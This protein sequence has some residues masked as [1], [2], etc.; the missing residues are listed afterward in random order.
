MNKVIIY[1]NKLGFIPKNLREVIRFAEE[2]KRF[3]IAEVGLNAHL[4]DVQVGDNIITGKGGNLYVLKTFDKSV[5]E[6]TGADREYVDNLARNY[7]L[8]K[9]NITSVAH[10][11]K[12]STWCKEMRPLLG[13]AHDENTN[14]SNKSQMKN[15]FKN[16]GERLKAQFY[17]EKAEGVR[18]AM[19]GNICVETP[20]GYVAIDNNYRLISYPC[21]A[22][23]DLPAYTIAKPFDQIK[24]GDVILRAKSYAKVRS[25][26]DG[27]ISVVGYSGNGSNVYPIKD[28]LL[29]QATVRV[30]VSFT[31]TVDGQINPMMLF[32]LSDDKKGSSMLPLL[33]LSQNGG[34]IAQNPMMLALLA[35]DGDFDLK[36]IMMYS[37]L[38]GQNPFTNL[39]APAAPA[40]PAEIKEVEVENE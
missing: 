12:F 2:N 31:G 14:K 35:G 19:D 13:D 10:R 20:E 22:V 28:F 37:M 4:Q 8:Q 3:R 16:L 17:P 30:V 21:E 7:D 36:D 9:S 27:K 11:I 33:M 25:I 40:A 29:G 26:K 6:L 32:A 38:G 18:I 24:E 5:D 23:I 34:N 1:T 39:F 15:S